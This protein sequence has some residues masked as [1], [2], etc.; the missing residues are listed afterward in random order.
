[1]SHSGPA[2]VLTLIL[3]SWPGG[4]LPSTLVLMRASLVSSVLES[5]QASALP[6]QSCAARFRRTLLDAGPV[7][8]ILA[9][10]LSAG[11]SA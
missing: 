11:R 10:L 5:V 9:T 7:V 3:A 4:P 2:S 1:M 6:P 8:A